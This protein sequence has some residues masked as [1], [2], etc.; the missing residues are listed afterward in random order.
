MAKIGRNDPCPCGS[1]KK[2]KQCCGNNKVVAFPTARVEEELDQQFHKF[3]DYLTEKYPQF[4]PVEIPNSQD[5]ELEVAVKLVYQGLFTKNRDGVTPMEEFIGKAKK[6]VLRPATLES[7]E[8]WKEARAGLF[9][10]ESV[11]SEQE[12]TVKD[13]FTGDTF[14]VD[15]DFIPLDTL[16]DAPYFVGIVLKWGNVYHFMPMALPNDQPAY[17]QLKTRVERDYEKSNPSSSLQQFFTEH[18]VTYMEQWM[19]GNNDLPP[20]ASWHGRPN[21]LEV[22]KLLNRNVH[23]TIQQREGFNELK[24]LWI[25]FCEGQAPVIRK[26]E[27]FAG[28]LEYMLLGTSFF[29]MESDITQKQ[30]AEKYGVNSNSIS[31]RLE[32]LEDYLF[33]LAGEEN[34]NEMRV[35]QAYFWVKPSQ[36]VELER[37][38]YE[39]HRKASS[40]DFATIEELNQFISKQ[41]H[42]A[43]IPSS[44]EEKA[45]IKVYDAFQAETESKQQKL[46]E[47]ALELDG[48]NVDALTLKARWAGD[49]EEHYLLKAVNAGLKSLEPGSLEGEAWRNMD[50]RPFLRAEEALAEYYVNTGRADKAISTYEEILEYNEND[51][52]GVRRVLFP[53]YIQEEDLSGAVVLLDNYP[54]D[55]AWWSFN[56]ALFLIKEAG[57]EEEITIAINKADRMNPYI[58]P[59]LKGEDQ[60]PEELPEQYKVGSWEEAVV[61]VHFTG[62]LWDPYLENII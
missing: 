16:E 14:F 3:Q 59:L 34:E 62:S 29:G 9:T 55:G 17:E 13:T 1:G 40:K 22:V 26:P 52:Q 12:V 7:L 51:D 57:R 8:A 30:L 36:H 54:E 44:N 47:E 35:P 61:Y 46:V 49:M 31:K 28:A 43:F 37:A 20:E 21:E 58:I 53:L 15:R 42:E 32:Q 11:D 10:L 50:A 24:R 23:S 56:A 18:F 33:E 25:K 41:Q 48:T 38:T 5:E 19:Y 60:L 4:L 39:M 45:Q 6:S 27:V 2:Y